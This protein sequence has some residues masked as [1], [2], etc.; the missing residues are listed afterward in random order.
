[1]NYINFYKCPHDGTKWIDKAGSIQNQS[2]PDCGRE[3]TVTRT[4]NLCDATAPGKNE[5]TVT[6]SPTTFGILEEAEYKALKAHLEMHTPNHYG[7]KDRQLGDIYDLHHVVYK[8]G[9]F[10]EEKVEIKSP[11]GLAVAAELLVRGTSF[12]EVA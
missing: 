11:E 5:F 10:I 9:N 3:V 1:M 4:A 6:F 12:V 7:N 2:C 8:A